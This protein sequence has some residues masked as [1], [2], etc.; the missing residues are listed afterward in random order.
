MPAIHA[1]VQALLTSA[2]RP[3]YDASSGVV[4][5]G[6]VGYY[7]QQL[8]A[9]VAAIASIKGQIEEA[10]QR[11]DRDDASSYLKHLVLNMWESQQQQGLQML[12]DHVEH[13]G[14]CID[15]AAKTINESKRTMNEAHAAANNQLHKLRLLKSTS[16]K[17]CLRQPS[18]SRPQLEMPLAGRAT[19]LQRQRRR[20]R[21][22]RERHQ[23]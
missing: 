8:P 19:L 18:T 5:P 12:Q 2:A 22:R 3:T 9:Y 15:V 6:S 23:H 10:H 14:Q 17:S 1:G 7:S 21:R 4:P 13:Q 20:Q 16:P 11:Q